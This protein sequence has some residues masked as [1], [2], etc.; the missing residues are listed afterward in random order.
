VTKLIAAY[1]NEANALQNR[2]TDGMWTYLQ[3]VAQT[4]KLATVKFS[5]GDADDDDDDDDDGGGDKIRYLFLCWLN[6]H[7]H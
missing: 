1:G 6:S 4:T 2:S 5:N 7:G 3:K